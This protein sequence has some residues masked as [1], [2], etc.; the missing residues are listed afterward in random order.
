M[1]TA[2]EVHPNLPIIRIYHDARSSE[3]QKNIKLVLKL[4]ASSQYRMEG[5][6]FIGKEVQAKHI[7]VRLCYGV[8]ILHY[9]VLGNLLYMAS[10]GFQLLTALSPY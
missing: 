7:F 9:I 6:K 3:C 1:L 10:N 8:D 2:S 4:N 5:V